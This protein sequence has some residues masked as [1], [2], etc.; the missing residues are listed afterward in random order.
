MALLHRN[1]AHAVKT[2]LSDSPVVF[3]QGARQTGKS[4]LARSL[5][6]VGHKARYLTLDDAATLSA[7]QSDP[8]GFIAGLD[9]PVIL[10]EV[11]RAPA[12]ALAI[13]AGVDGDRKPGRFLLTGSANVLLLHRIAE[14]LAGRIEIHTLWPLSQGEL[15]GRSDN[16]LDA[17]FERRFTAPKTTGE[18]RRKLIA[19]MSRGG[20]PEMLRRGEPSRRQAWF[21][22]FIT[23][24][25]QRDVR[26]IANIR[27]LTDLPRLLALAA[28]RA[29]GLLDFADLSRGLSMPQTTLKRY[30]GLLEATFL[31]QLL[32]AW[33]AN[34][35]KRLVKAPKLLIN[36][37]GLLLHLLGA[38]SE[39]LISDPNLMG[40]VLE[41]FIAMELLKQRG[42]SKSQANLFHFRTHTGEE[43]D[44]V[45][46]DPAGR[47]VGVEIKAA[48]S[49]NASHFKGLHALAQTAG[50][51]FLRGILLYGGENVVPFGKDM[52]ALP[53][54][55]VW[56]G[57]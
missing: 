26:D 55:C 31:I 49:I 52:L 2:S 10:D 48:A 1:L 40:S 29:A 41:N 4:T 7:A 47:V 51:R 12:L 3:I 44:L 36:D 5:A 33:F 32:P 42:W 22:S 14:S 27:D 30:M 23:T 8:Q 15:A 9:G 6:S 28:S 21:G 18:S 38:G 43:V 34:I 13:K 25:L 46:E 37:S 45:L 24:L 56:L 57:G 16:F 39:R 53:L 20:Y 50:P 11:Q 17:L 54:S 19:R 35:G